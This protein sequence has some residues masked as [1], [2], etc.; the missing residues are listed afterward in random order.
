MEGRFLLRRGPALLSCP[1]SPEATVANARAG[2]RAEGQPARSHFG[3]GS[4]RRLSVPT[5]LPS[6][7]GNRGWLRLRF[8][9]SRHACR[10]GPP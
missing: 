8:L 1:Q 6:C 2:Q 4:T 10:D 5:R 3:R 7:C 9:A